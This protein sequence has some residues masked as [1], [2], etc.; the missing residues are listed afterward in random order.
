MLELDYDDF[1]SELNAGREIE[2]LFRGVW[3]FFSTRKKKRALNY[4]FYAM[5]EPL[6]SECAYSKLEELCNIE[7]QGCAL[8]DVLAQL[9]DYIIY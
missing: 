5:N 9:Q 4:I 1:L 2:I 3:Y 8:E 7:I 6:A